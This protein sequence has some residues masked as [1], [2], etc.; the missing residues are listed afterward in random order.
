MNDWPHAPPHRLTE[1]GVYMITAGIFQ[2][3]HLLNTD[4][5]RDIFCRIFFACM[6]EFE[7]ELHAWAV[8]SNHYHFLASSLS[9]PGTLQ[10]GISK[11]HTLSAKELNHQDRQPGRKVWFQYFDSHI[12]FL[13]SYLPRLKYVHNNPVHHGIV[14]SAEEYRWCSAAWFSRNATPAFQKTVNSFK[15]DTISVPD[16][17]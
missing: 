12:T 9:D 3:A 1:N 15:T 10:K 11:L 8:L 2:K 14:A 4:D 16:S 7:W 5:R 6:L 13:N 17:F